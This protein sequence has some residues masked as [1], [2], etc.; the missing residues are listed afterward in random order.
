MPA[1]SSGHSHVLT[2]LLVL[3]WF[4]LF[5]GAQGHAEEIR[6][7]PRETAVTLA[8]N[9]QTPFEVWNLQELLSQQ[10]YLD[11]DSTDGQ[12]GPKT[13]SAVNR[14]RAAH[15]LSAIATK[16]AALDEAALRFYRRIS[17]VERKLR[18][19]LCSTGGPNPRDLLQIKYY[20]V[21]A[22]ALRL[23][24]D[25]QLQASHGAVLGDRKRIVR[26]AVLDEFRTLMRLFGEDQDWSN[27][28]ESWL[29]LQVNDPVEKSV[30]PLEPK[31]PVR[32]LT[33]EGNYGFPVAQELNHIYT[34][35]TWPKEYNFMYGWVY[36]AYNELHDSF[37]SDVVPYTSMWRYLAQSDLDRYKKNMDKYNNYMRKL[38]GIK[39]SEW[40]ILEGSSE[41]SALRHY[42]RGNLPANL[43]A[44]TLSFQICGYG[45]AYAE[46]FIYMP[47]VYVN[48]AVIENMSTDPVR[49]EAIDFERISSPR[50]RPRSSAHDGAAASE[51]IE[52]NLA[53]LQSGNS[54]I[55]P[56]NILLA[57][58]NP[59]GSP[60]DRTF[61]GSQTVEAY[62]KSI[63]K[64][65]AS[66]RS[67][68]TF[69][70]PGPTKS[71]RIR[72][73]RSSFGPPTWPRLQD[74]VFGPEFKIRQ[75]RLGSDRMV[76][77]APDPNTFN[78]TTGGGAGSC[79]Y[80]L[81]WDADRGGYVNHGK[82]IDAAN[83]VAREQTE[84]RRFA[85][86]KLRFRL[87]ERELEV[88]HINMVKLVLRLTN[89]RTI[90]LG[91]PHA[92]LAQ[93]DDAYARILAHQALD[94]AFA[95]PEGVEARDVRTSTLRIKGYYQR[96][97]SFGPLAEDIG[98]SA[99]D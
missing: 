89:G 45:E 16:A 13:R 67:N 86:L 11:A 55:V 61:F 35:K 80:L 5:P 92:D 8:V 65:I 50:L 14:L 78:L 36:G 70:R 82:V 85:G 76:S 23:F 64:R 96:Y 91:A 17:K 95:L 93:D 73:I 28:G 83:G 42:S 81:A 62:A 68:K 7:T 99:A 3:V 29:V 63:Y 40:R 15:G 24:L 2:S 10:G 56:L 41:I 31:K 46:G 44:L 94:V 32:M 58:N 26:N 84:V 12:W 88:A 30:S 39:N 38:Y 37:E 66:Y 60:R 43:V 53:K 90:T 57:A 20:R 25:G 18:A 34:R 4:G 52:A 22:N 72:K 6:C 51:P 75:I 9:L 97:G 71:R 33:V 21:G 19:Q 59:M 79:P 27:G 87:E 77:R 48:V 47:S 49:I 1:Q 74:Y 69:T 98:A 54:L